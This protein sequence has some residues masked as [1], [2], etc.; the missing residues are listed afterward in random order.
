MAAISHLT[1]LLASMTPVLRPGVFVFCE[2]PDLDGQLIS[3]LSSVVVVQ[4]DEAVTVVIPKD[5][6]TAHGLSFGPA[7]R[8]I[9][10]TVHSGLEAVGLTAA[11]AAALAERGVSANVVAGSRHDHIF[12]PERQAEDAMAALTALQAR[13]MG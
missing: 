4:E 12:V 9:S 3:T 13:S 7:M 10:L 5:V 6:A 8:M 2:L 1:T 11:F